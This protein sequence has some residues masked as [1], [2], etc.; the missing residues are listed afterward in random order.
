MNRCSYN[1]Y[2][3]NRI[4]MFRKLLSNNSSIL[5]E[6]FETLA[7]N[8]CPNIP[9]TLPKSGSY[10]KINFNFKEPEK[11]IEDIFSDADLVIVNFIVIFCYKKMCLNFF[12]L[13]QDLETKLNMIWLMNM[14]STKNK[15][16]V[17]S[18]SK[19][20]KTLLY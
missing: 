18:K 15:S 16:E 12:L 4:D 19:F 10:P 7:K 17:K 1:S 20:K 3:L 11:N 8:N 2:D 9:A 13:R 5:R 14:D 6:K